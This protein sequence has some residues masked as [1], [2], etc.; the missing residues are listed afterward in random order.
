M[1]PGDSVFSSYDACVVFTARQTTCLTN[2]SNFI[3]E[4]I[5]KLESFDLVNFYVMSQ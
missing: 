4:T 1:G 2:V 5:K 3:D